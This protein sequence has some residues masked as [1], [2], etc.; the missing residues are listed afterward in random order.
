MARPEQE[1]VERAIGALGLGDRLVAMAD[2]EAERVYRSIEDPFANMRGGRWIWE[3]FRVP[4]VSKT[5]GDDRAFAR[6]PRIVPEAAGPLTFF[7]GSDGDRICAYT[8]DLE[9]V[10]QVLGECPAFEYLIVPPGLEWLVGENHHG[11][12]YAVGEPVATRLRS[13]P[14]VAPPP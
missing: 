4:Y 13:I 10:V 6:L 1:Q 12:L 2:P 14:S 8:G 7:P 5:F 3:H 9:A 11:V